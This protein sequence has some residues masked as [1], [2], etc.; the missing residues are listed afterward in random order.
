MPNPVLYLIDECP[1]LGVDACVMDENDTLVFISFWGR[2]TA[3]QQFI[4]RLTLGAQTCGLEQFHLL[5]DDGHTV[6]VKVGNVE[7]LEKRCLRA[8]RHTLFGSLTNLWLFDQR[9]I[10][11]DKANVSAIA[12]MPG[13]DADEEDRL[14]AMVQ[15]TCPLPLLDHWKTH[16]LEELRTRQML[17]CL[18]YVFGSLKGYRLVIDLPVFTNSL[19]DM[20]RSGVLGIAPQEPL[21]LAV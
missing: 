6:Q 15:E 12:L 18:P 5:A 7:R 9:A 20:I 8:Y 19:R 1:D 4:A 2:D 10:N 11:A 21:R 13:A 17:T 3:I 16:I 14:W